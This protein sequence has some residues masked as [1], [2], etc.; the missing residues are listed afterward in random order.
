MADIADLKVAKW[1]ESENR[2]HSFEMKKLSDEFAKQY[3]TEVANNERMLDRMR[4]EYEVKTRNLENELDLK[5]SEMRKSQEKNLEAENK[6]L[7]SEVQNLKSAH[8]D[9]VGELKMGQQNEINTLVDS[10]RR[11]L[12]DARQR[13]IKE[14]MKYE[15]S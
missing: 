4:R 7:S 12:E 6:P 5:L 2:R 13:Y 14:K 8:Q 9:Q 10:H 15:V 11:T 1:K 3:Q